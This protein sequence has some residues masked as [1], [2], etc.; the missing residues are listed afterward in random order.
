MQIKPGLDLSDME[1]QKAWAFEI[2]FDLLLINTHP[3]SPQYT[4]HW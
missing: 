1:V 3:G 2:A 4:A